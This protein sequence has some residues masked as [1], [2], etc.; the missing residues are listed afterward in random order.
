MTGDDR[1][2][3]FLLLTDIVRLW[4]VRGDAIAMVPN[5]DTLFIAGSDDDRGLEQMLRIATAAE[6][7]PRPISGIALRLDGDTWVPWMP[8]ESH[9]LYHGF[10]ELQLRSLE[11]AYDAQQ[12]L[13]EDNA[14]D[15]FIAPFFFARRPDRTTTSVT[16]WPVI[17][18]SMLPKAEIIAFKSHGTGPAS[19]SSVTWQGAA[20]VVGNLMEPLDM[21]PP[22]FRVREF[23][24]AEQ[25]AWL[26]SEHR[27][28]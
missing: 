3:S 13:L 23:P 16:I 21:Y 15:V 11:V 8:R 4:D 26:A 7:F 19:T 28:E 25:L 14:E 17:G 12:E 18:E 24:S 20:S 2:P 5:R 6:E 9:A 22:R 1:S 27:A 10:K